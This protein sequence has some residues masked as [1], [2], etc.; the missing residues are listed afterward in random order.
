VSHGDELSTDTTLTRREFTLESALAIL[1]AVT[2]TI[3]ACG[4]DDGSPASPSPQGGATGTISANHGHTATITSAQLTAGGAVTL[5]IQG[6]A[7]H[8]HTVSVTAA[9]VGQIASRQQVTVTSTT[10]DG[11]SH[12][13]TFN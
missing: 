9:Q 12:T 11:H 5:N 1:A 7:T 6:N 10:E 4:D 8:P 13:V 2:I 3:T